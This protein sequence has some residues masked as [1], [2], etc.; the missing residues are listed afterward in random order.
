MSGSPK[1]FSGSPAELYERH[2]VPLLFEP[3]ARILA[4]RLSSLHR[5]QVLEIAAGTGVVTRALC[6]T[7]PSDVQ[8]IATDLNQLMLEQAMAVP[9]MD[10]VHWKVAD[11][12]SLPFDDET[13]DAIVCQFGAMFFPDKGAAFTEANRVLKPGGTLLSS[14]W[15]RMERN[16]I[17]RVYQDILEELFPENP[18][19]R[20]LDPFTYSDP[21]VIR[22]DLAST[23]FTSIDIEVVPEWCRADSARE[24][25]LALAYGHPVR[26]EIEARI[27]EHLGRATRLLTERLCARYGSGSVAIPNQALLATARRP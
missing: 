12:M 6:E 5:G 21:D 22:A 4:S 15:D 1:A 11:A 27:P 25:A 19:R 20:M 13:F 16:V 10:R 26:G 7:L 2:L 17:N 18:P 24:A 14:V 23:G 8:I 3:H 9:G